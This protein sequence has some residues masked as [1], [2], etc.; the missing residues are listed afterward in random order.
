MTPEYAAQLFLTPARK[1]PRTDTPPF[2]D[3]LVTYPPLHGTRV[4]LWE[5]G[6][7]PRVLLVHGWEGASGDLS[8]FAAALI[9]AGYR[10]V[11][12]D[13]PAHGQSD[14]TQTSIVACARAITQLLADIGPVRAI[15]AH[16]VGCAIAIEALKRGARAD[17]AVLIAPPAR[18]RD[19][20]LSFAAQAGLSGENIGK[21]IAH[22]LT[23]DVDVASI[24]A[25]RA[26]A[27]LD[28][29]ALIVHSEDDRVVPASL[30]REIAAAWPGARFLSVNGLG[31]RRILQSDDVIRSAVEFVN[32]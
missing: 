30:G 14:G 3:A 26:V 18:Y 15:V 7:G 20:A 17:A 21:M 12:P 10:V 28:T 23:L 13:L 2:D 19:Y 32:G 29:P 5:A 1:I 22:L 31:H 4:A 11:A 25:P 6:N 8:A 24:D 27:A 9:D 16:S